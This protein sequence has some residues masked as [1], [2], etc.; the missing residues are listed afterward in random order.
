MSVKVA[1]VGSGP[2]GCYLAQALQRAL[3]DSELTIID[4]L[5]VPY[6]LIRYGVAPDHQGTKSV[7]KQFARLFERGG[8]NFL[9][10]VAVGA[11]ILLADLQEL[12]DIVVLA[13]GLSADRKLGAG[14]DDLSA[15]YGAGKLTRYWNGHPE[16]ADLAPQLG[17]VVCVVGTG[18]VAIDV[19]RLLAK[20]P[21]DFDGS[22]ITG[23]SLGAGV[24]HIHVLGRSPASAAKFDPAMIRELANI[25]G[26]GVTFALPLPDQNATPVVE[27]LQAIDGQ[28]GTGNKTLTFHFDTAL[29][30]P[31]MTDGRLTAVTVNEAGVTTTLPC[32][33][34]V[35]AIGFDAIE[36]EHRGALLATAIDA[37]H[38]H[39][40]ERLFATG[41]FRRGPTGTIAANR[42][43]AKEV[44]ARIV[45][46]LERSPPSQN[47]LGHS[48]LRQKIGHQTTNY[49]D[50]L[51]L[52]GIEQAGAAPNRVRS[53]IT[54]QQAM[55]A[56]CAENESQA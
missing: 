11:D 10:N 9:G 12:F 43:D 54:S 7:T 21:E 25:A 30:S 41:W 33:S 42:V 14:F 8:V 52:D 55:L 36:P 46:S 48:A 2:S 37:D 50:W 28:R 31:V 26:L 27:A 6:G 53:K 4:R 29:Q 19:V 15:V 18:N 32:D 47:R 3:P 34:I 39:L 1:V 5:P 17:R 23:D 44:A 56:L 35:T 51:I 49:A 22:D 24:E 16:A 45:A 13:T 40:Q 20:G 38:G